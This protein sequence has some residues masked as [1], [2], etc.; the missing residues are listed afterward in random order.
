[1]YALRGEGGGFS[2]EFAN[3]LPKKIRKSE[4]SQPTVKTKLPFLHTK[5][6]HSPSHNDESVPK[7]GSPKRSKASK[8]PSSPHLK[9]GRF[10]LPQSQSPS[11][12]GPM[13]VAAAA[14][15]GQGLLEVRATSARRS[16][17]DRR[18]SILLVERCGLGL[19]GGGISVSGH[20]A[21]SCF[22]RGG[23]RERE[24][25]WEGV[26]RYGGEGSRGGREWVLG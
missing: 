12:S 2:Y 8:K 5:K 19:P 20:G 4:F 11:A 26:R 9:K 24:G 23:E 13:P 10:H 6:N 21:C 25:V 22:L 16:R 14:A 3:H 15:T 1:M 7:R 17:S 18:M